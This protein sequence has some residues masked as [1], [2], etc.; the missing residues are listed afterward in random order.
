MALLDKIGINYKQL[1]DGEILKEVN[2]YAPATG[3]IKL[4]NISKGMVVEPNQ[5]IMELYDL[6]QLTISMPLFEKDAMNVHQADT[7]FFYRMNEKDKV[8]RAV[9]TQI[10]KV[11]DNETHTVIVYAK[12]ISYES[13]NLFINSFVQVEIIYHDRLVKAL[14]EEAVL[15]Q[16]NNYYI[17]ILKEQQGDSLFIFQKRMV[18]VGATDQNYVEVLDTINEKVIIKGATI[19]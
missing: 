9:I 2:I 11:V 8:Y 14:P 5:P 18:N 17:Y 15:R 6:S 3:Y 19:L 10:S 7:V 12:P 4:S 13:L 16:N 1:Q